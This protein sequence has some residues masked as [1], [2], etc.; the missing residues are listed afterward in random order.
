MVRAHLKRSDVGNEAV[1]RSF[2]RNQP[3]LE[4]APE[5]AFQGAGDRV[6][7]RTHRHRALTQLGSDAGVCVTCKDGLGDR[8]FAADHVAVN[9][10][11]HTLHYF[12]VLREV[13]ECAIDL[14]WP[15]K[16]ELCGGRLKLA[17]SN[18]AVR[19]R[20]TSRIAAAPDAL[21]LAAGLLMT[22]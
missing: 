2:S 14:R 11:F 8:K 3:I 10:G 17:A 5:A 12:R 7:G 1:F 13:G 21:S 22:E 4:P 19:V 9:D 15:D 20:A 18:R 6:L 16:P